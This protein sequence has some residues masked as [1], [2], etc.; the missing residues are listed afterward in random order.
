MEQEIKLLIAKARDTVRLCEVRNTPK[1]MGF[2]SLSESSEIRKNIKEPNIVFFGGYDDAE[3]R[4]FGAL[5]EYLKGS[6]DAFPIDALKIFYRKVDKLSHRDVL[7]SFM[8]TGITRDKIGDI[9][10]GDGFALAFV[11]NEI[12]D[13]LIEQVSKIG[14]VG[15]EITKLPIDEVQNVFPPSQFEDMSFTVSS[16][17]LDAIVSSLLGLSRTKAEQMIIDGVVFVNSFAITK[18]IKKVQSGDKI[19]VRGYGKFIITETG[20]LSK[21]GREII[22][23]K[24]YI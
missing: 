10:F 17:R 20:A 3:R 12:S 2:L 19:T 15:V 23:A 22:R 1:F 14:R 11:A 18:S 5:P 21:K 7:G 24:K 4:M 8:A 6:Y 16:P 9:R 13:Y